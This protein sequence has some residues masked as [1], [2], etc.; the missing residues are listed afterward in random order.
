MPRK[1]DFD[2]ALAKIVKS[3]KRAKTITHQ[4]LSNVRRHDAIICEVDIAEL[5]QETVWLVKREADHKGI[6]MRLDIDPSARMIWTDPNQ[7]RQVLINLLTNAVHAIAKQGRITIQ[8]KNTSNGVMLSVDDTGSG[9]PQQ[10]LEKIFEPFFSTKPPKEGTG[11]G[12][13]VS[14]EIVAKLGGSIK[15]ES[16]VGRGTRF[17][18]K[19]PDQKSEGR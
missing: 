9:I 15:V 7:V 4:L 17:D 16:R 6:E 13:F 2:K 18:I 5:A 8:T 1:A 3:V 12:L 10:D 19:I 14:R 11:L